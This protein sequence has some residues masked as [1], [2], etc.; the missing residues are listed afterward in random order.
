MQGALDSGIGDLLGVFMLAAF[1]VTAGCALICI[2]LSWWQAR[3]RRRRAADAVMVVVQSALR[4]G[5]DDPVGLAVDQAAHGRG[6]LGGAATWP[7]QLFR[8]RRVTST[9]FEVEELPPGAS[10]SSEER[11]C[12][13][14]PFAVKECATTAAASPDDDS[15]EACEVCC[16]CQ[17]EIVFLPCSHGGIC[18]SCAEQIVRRSNR[19]CHTCRRA[20]EKVVLV[21]EPLQLLS[22]LQVSA[23]RVL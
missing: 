23:R 2:G 20:V 21:E 12:A 1:V 17:P 5:S 6:K 16:E 8:V 10:P 13:S 18:R 7:E 14:V 22:G 3:L 15:E 11:E 19:H 4:A 9:L